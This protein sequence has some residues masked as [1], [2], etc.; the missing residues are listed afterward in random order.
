M[1]TFALQNETLLELSNKEKGRISYAL[2]DVDMFLLSLPV[3]THCRVGARKGEA[4]PIGKE[5]LK[6]SAS[7][8]ACRLARLA[9]LVPP[10]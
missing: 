1:S 10:C 2:P 7:K 6:S 4:P 3:S 8:Y 5:E 9:A